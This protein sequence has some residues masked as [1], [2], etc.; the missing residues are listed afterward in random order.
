MA[1][2]DFPDPY[3]DEILPGRITVDTVSE[4]QRVWAF[5]HPKPEFDP[6]Q[7]VVIPKEHI[8]SLA[9]ITEH[10]PGLIREMMD[11]L[12]GVAERVAAE[13][14][15]CQVHC[16]LGEYQHARHLHWQV[17]KDDRMWDFP[18]IDTAPRHKWSS[19]SAQRWHTYWTDYWD[20]WTKDHGERPR[21]PDADRYRH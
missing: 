17:L 3:C 15:A 1:Y 5:H 21:R 7:I 13:F 4:T 2:P 14:G 18:P 8:D 19:E 20:R 16:N 10:D 6:V 9:T 11:V 12:S